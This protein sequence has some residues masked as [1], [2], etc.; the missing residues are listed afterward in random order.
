MIRRRRF[1][2]GVDGELAQD[3]LDVAFRREFET[4]SAAAISLLLRPSDTCSRTSRSRAE[5]VPIWLRARIP[6]LA[7]CMPSTRR[8][9]M[10]H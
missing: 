7:A 3:V 6:S 8:K 2:T 10:S 1:P 4:H 5:S 9:A